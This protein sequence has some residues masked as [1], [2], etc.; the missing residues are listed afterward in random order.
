MS[1]GAAAEGKV[2]PAEKKKQAQLSQPPTATIVQP[3]TRSQR[4]VL[5]MTGPP[6]PFVDMDVDHDEVGL[7]FRLRFVTL[8]KA[9]EVLLCMSKRTR[10]AVSVRHMSSC[11]VQQMYLGG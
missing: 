9:I 5:T 6:G 11:Y 2:G 10:K 3:D 4:L 1:S 7:L 8:R